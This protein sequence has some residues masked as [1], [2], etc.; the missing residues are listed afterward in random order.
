MC[1]VLVMVLVQT[2]VPV[3]IQLVPVFA[4][5]IYAPMLLENGAVSSPFGLPNHH[6]Q[7]KLHSPR[8][9]C[10]LYPIVL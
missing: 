7:V 1:N 8:M 5:A 6:L 4:Y 10:L 2:K 9:H 3:I